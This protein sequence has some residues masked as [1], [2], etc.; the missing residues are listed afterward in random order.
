MEK[1]TK[2]NIIKY[3]NDLNKV[4]FKNFKEK[5]LDLFFSM[6]LKLKEKK[7]EEVS[8]KFSDLKKI[9][10]L[11]NGTDK[12]LIDIVDSCTDKILTLKLRKEDTDT[13]IKLILFSKFEINK[14]EKTLK[15]KVNP[16]FQY[17]LNNFIDKYTIMNHKEYISLNS[18]FDKNL[19]RLLKQWDTKKERNFTIDEFKELLDIKDSYKMSDIDKQILKIKNGKI[20]ADFSKYF[21][22]LKIEKI[23]EGR[24]VT[25]LKFSWGNQNIV[26]AEIIEDVVTNNER[27][28]NIIEKA[29]KNIYINRSKLLFSKENIEKLLKKYDLYDVEN[30]LDFAYKHIKRNFKKLSYIE[31]TI[32][33]YIS[34]KEETKD[35]TK[36]SEKIEIKNNKI[37]EEIKIEKDNKKE[38][39]LKDNLIGVSEKKDENNEELSLLI[40]S[41]EELSLEE[42]EKFMELEKI[43]IPTIL[44]PIKI[45]SEKIYINSLKNSI[46]T[47]YGKLYK[48][49]LK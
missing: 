5:E 15:V 37:E 43:E 10:D 1:E 36:K 26:A 6:C 30:G 16:D 25:S 3:N 9:I 24:K 7:T 13:I 11:K 21:K 35:L 12:T 48:N 8:F 41:L 19:Y 49:N 45:S 28:K 4:Q 44:K 22:N 47:Y 17:I 42:L 46:K 32:D 39:I 20:N 14:L 33:T 2:K 23:K 40:K 31:K 29:N 38:E 34:S 18:K 27:L